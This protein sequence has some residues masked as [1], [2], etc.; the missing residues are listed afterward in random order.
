MV[1]RAFSDP[2]RVS[3][4]IASPSGDE[5]EFVVETIATDRLSVA[6]LRECL[7]GTSPR[8]RLTADD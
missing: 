3:E 2:D 8:G 1:L 4:D 6:V 5:E 7:F